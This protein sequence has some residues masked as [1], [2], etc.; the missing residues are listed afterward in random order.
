MLES[1]RESGER[2]IRNLIG[3]AV[4]KNFSWDN[5]LRFEP[6]GE[7]IIAVTPVDRSRLRSRAPIA[8]WRDR[9]L[10]RPIYL[11]I[12]WMMLDV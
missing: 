1:Y 8:Q 12:E 2:E 7:Q 4:P 11:I 10:L 6:E 3:A 9:R 5:L